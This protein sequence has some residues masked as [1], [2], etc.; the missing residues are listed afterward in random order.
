MAESEFSKIVSSMP[1]VI[2]YNDTGSRI[3]LLQQVLDELGQPDQKFKTIHIAGTNG[4]G[5]TSEMIYQLLWKTGFKVGIFSSPAFCDDREQIRADGELISEHDFVECYSRLV[6]AFD[7]LGYT[8]QDFSVFETWYLVS[9]IYFAERSSDYVVY[10]CGMGGELDATNA[11][12]NVEYAIFTKIDMDHMRFLGST[13][14][15]IA[16][17][18]SKIIKPGIKVVSYPTQ[19][20]RAEHILQKEADFQKASLTQSSSYNVALDDEQLTHS[21]VSL[22]YKKHHYDDVYFNL[23]GLYQIKNL[24]NVLNWLELFNQNSQTQISA[25]TLLQ[26]LKTV[27]LP[28]RMQQLQKDP[29]VVLDAAHNVNAIKGLVDSLTKLHSNKKL[30]LV[31]GFL[32]DKQYQK[33]VDLLLE[34]SATFIVTSPNNLQRALPASQLYQV[35][36]DDPESDGKDVILASSIADAVNKAKQVDPC[37]L[38]IFTGS[39]YL[40][41]QIQPLWNE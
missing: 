30:I 41:N 17:A 37:D 13:I 8:Q 22:Y 6:K 32:K 20:S 27:S 33:C 34:L 15:E 9:T 29:L 1:Q 10:E 11:T 25:A 31:V 36:K 35:F 5:S 23:G 39:F 38:V 14:E 18:K 2:K 24:Q 40:I 7:N 3:P 4:K 28:G 16:T 12:R 19:S 26:V 21:I